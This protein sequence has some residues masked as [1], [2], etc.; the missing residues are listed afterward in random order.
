MGQITAEWLL[1]QVSYALIE[2]IVNTSLS[3]PVTA[4]IRTVTPLNMQ[5]IYQGV[6][7]VI[8][9]GTQIEV[10]GVTS[11]TAS[12]FTAT[13]VNTHAGFG[14]AVVGA[15]FSGGQPNTPLWSQ[16]E[17]LD[18]L[19][20]TQ[21]EF[22]CAV[23]PVYAVAT[24]NLEVG[25]PSYPNPADAIRVERIAVA[26]TELWNVSQTDIDWQGGYSSRAGQ[27]PQYWYQDKVGPFNFAVDPIP[28]VGAVA[29]LF[30]SQLGSTSLGLLSTFTVPD[31]FWPALKWG[32]LAKAL[33]KDGEQRDLSRSAYCQ[34]KFTFWQI[35]AS[36]FMEGLESRFASAEET[37]EPVL[38]KMGKG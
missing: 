19:T 7:L 1:E 29:E 23:R 36:K 10:V 16:Q 21:N 37:V 20:S 27:Q 5:G 17:M 8:G 13:F 26:G 34:Q 18:Y 22:L 24:A 6:M 30:Y 35:L 4:G 32:T 33:S 15:T 28:Q 38:A 11:V 2:V 14:P 25:I 12:T 9:Q 3:A 31:L